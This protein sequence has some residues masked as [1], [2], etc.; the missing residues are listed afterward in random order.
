MSDPEPSLP[1]LSD[2]SLKRQRQAIAWGSGLFLG[3]GIGGAIGF[4]LDD[5]SLGLAV[6]VAIVLA[7]AAA[8]LM[9]GYVSAERRAVDIVARDERRDNEDE[10]AYDEDDPGGG[11]AR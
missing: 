11:H 1:S 4:S 7:T 6:G 5:Y 2:A 3:I 8:Y 10:G 9:S